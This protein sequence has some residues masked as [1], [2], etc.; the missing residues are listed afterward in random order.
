[1]KKKGCCAQYNYYVNV[2][3]TIESSFS[4]I[5]LCGKPKNLKRKQSNAGMSLRLF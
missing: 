3:Y 2:L 1:M 5:A 4:I